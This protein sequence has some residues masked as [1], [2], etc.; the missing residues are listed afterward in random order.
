MEVSSELSEEAL[1]ATED[2]DEDDED[3]DDGVTV[4]D[5]E[6]TD[7]TIYHLVRE[8][9]DLLLDYVSQTVVGRLVNGEKVECEEEE[10]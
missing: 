3:E 1:T 7:G 4:E 2:E 8:K 5:W 6:D 9:G 10:D